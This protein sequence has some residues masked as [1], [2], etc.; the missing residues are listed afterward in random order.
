MVYR[1]ALNP[2]AAPPPPLSATGLPVP[3][4]HGDPTITSTD[5]DNVTI[6]NANGTSA[7]L[8]LLSLVIST[9]R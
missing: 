2:C 7:V 4:A 5:G 8:N 3:G 9:P 1:G 6:T